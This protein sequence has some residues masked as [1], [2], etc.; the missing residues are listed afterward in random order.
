M[1]AVPKFNR[2]TAIA[3]DRV[4]GMAR[5]QVAADVACCYVKGL[6]PPIAV[7]VL[8]DEYAQDPMF[9]KIVEQVILVG[10]RSVTDVKLR[11]PLMTRGHTLIV[12]IEGS[13]G[14]T[15]G[16]LGVAKRVMKQW[17]VVDLRRLTDLARFVATNVEERTHVHEKPAPR[18]KQSGTRL[19]ATGR[20]QA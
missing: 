8:R 6:L 1:G 3:L 4:V 12:A 18:L 11:A 9:E 19:R 13:D 20:K 15:L 10:E 5:S 2:P 7:A 16:A 17:S 14:T